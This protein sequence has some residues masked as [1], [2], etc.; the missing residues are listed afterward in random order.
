M[1]RDELS[2]IIRAAART[3]DDP[4]VVVIGVDPKGRLA[5]MDLNRRLGFAL[6]LATAAMTAAESPIATTV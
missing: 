2:H 4:N 5:R 1:K 6:P 3:L